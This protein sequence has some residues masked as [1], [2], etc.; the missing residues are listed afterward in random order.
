MVSTTPHRQ[1]PSI[2]VRIGASKMKTEAKRKMG[3]INNDRTMSQKK[4]F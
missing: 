2:N 1:I 4:T 3:H